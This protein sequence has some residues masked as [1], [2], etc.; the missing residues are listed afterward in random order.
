[1]EKEIYQ[2]QF[3]IGEILSESWKRFTENFK[4][5]LII[6]LIIYVPINIIL[7]LI[8]IEGSF[9]GF[10]IYFKIIQ[11]LESF[12]GIIATM[13]IAFLI[14]NKI[15][16]KSIS[17]EEAFK[18]SLSKWGTV[19]G[20]NILLGLFI[21]GLTI[22][23]IIPGIIFGIYWAFTMFAVIF[24]NKSY[25]NAL[26]YSKS[27][28]KGRWWTVAGYSFVFGILAIIA[29]FIGGIPYWFLPDNIISNIA[30]DTL[31]DILYSFFIVVSTIFFINF[32]ATKQESIPEQNVDTPKN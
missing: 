6:T 32:N 18:K 19:I 21:L 7:S 30:T 9:E 10:R 16:D 1:M 20:T 25:K 12:I 28:V 3:S 17:V 8:P 13:A 15:D 29:G 24:K 11:F 23:L 22:L 26:D 4:L 5:I 31:I 27:I 14:K 2:K